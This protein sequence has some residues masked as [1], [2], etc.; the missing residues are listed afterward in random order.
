MHKFEFP[1]SQSCGAS[2][3]TGCVPERCHQLQAFLFLFCSG[4]WSNFLLEGGH[5]PRNKIGAASDSK[6]LF[7]MR[8]LHPGVHCTSAML[9]KI[10]WRHWNFSL[11]ACAWILDATFSHSTTFVTVICASAFETHIQ[12]RPTTSYFR[13][14]CRRSCIASLSSHNFSSFTVPV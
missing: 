9:R 6:V 11:C 3:D 4:R 5:N 1:N 2:C 12:M 14:A 13:A 7:C 8:S 10:N